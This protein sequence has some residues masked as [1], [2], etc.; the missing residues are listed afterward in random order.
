MKI[1][2]DPAFVA[3]VYERKTATRDVVTVIEWAEY[4]GSTL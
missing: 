1:H 3:Y 2:L 4:I